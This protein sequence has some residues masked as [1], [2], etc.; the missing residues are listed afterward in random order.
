MTIETFIFVSLNIAIVSVVV[1]SIAAI[2]SLLVRRLASRHWILVLGLAASLCTFVAVPLGSVYQ[3]SLLPGVEYPV[4]AETTKGDAGAITVSSNTQQRSA[5]INDAQTDVPEI[6]V[7][8]SFQPRPARV[9]S[10]VVNKAMLPSELANIDSSFGNLKNESHTVKATDLLEHF[11]G[12]QH[13]GVPPVLMW[14]WTIAVLVWCAGTAIAFLLQ[15]KNWFRVRTA[16]RIKQQ[17]QDPEL[18]RLLSDVSSRLGLQQIPRAFVSPLIPCPVVSAGVHAQLILPDDYATRFSCE[19][20]QLILAHELAHLKRGDHRVVLLQTV[21][22]IVFWWNPILRFLSHGISCLRELICDGM[23]IELFGNQQLFARTMI[24]IAE[25][26]SNGKP[27]PTAQL[28]MATGDLEYRVRQILSDQAANAAMRSSRRFVIISAVVTLAVVASTAFAQISLET[29]DNHSIVGEFEVATNNSMFSPHIE[30]QPRSSDGR[31]SDSVGDSEIAI[32][33]EEVREANESDQGVESQSRS[34]EPADSSESMADV[35]FIGQRTGRMTREVHGQV[36]MPDGTPAR[37]S[38]LSLTNHWRNPAETLEADANGRFAFRCSVLGQ[39]FIYVATDSSGAFQKVFNLE[40]KS[41]C[42]L[43]DRIDVEIQLDHCIDREIRVVDPSGVPIAGANVFVNIGSPQLRHVMHG[44]SDSSG[45]FKYRHAESDAVFEIV[46]FKSGAGFDYLNPEA[47]NK[48]NEAEEMLRLTSA[49]DKQG[50]LV[51]SGVQ[52]RE[53]RVV[54]ES[55]RPVVG[56]RLSVKRLVKGTSEPLSVSSYSNFLAT[57]TDEQGRAVFDWFPNWQT[58]AVEASINA[59][60]FARQSKT[61]LSQDGGSFGKI[62]LKRLVRVS[63]TVVDAN[64]QPV[65]RVVVRARGTIPLED[66]YAEPTGNDGRFELGMLPNQRVIVS[67]DDFS[68]L[69]AIRR[70]DASVSELRVLY[71]PGAYSPIDEVL[72][73]MV[74][75]V[76]VDVQIVNALNGQPIKT[77]RLR[78]TRF[79]PLQAGQNDSGAGVSGFAESDGNGLA[80]LFLAPG[81][82]MLR[83]NDENEFVNL[84]LKAGQD[85]KIVLKTKSTN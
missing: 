56:A 9:D 33:R 48:N 84:N 2:A 60:D 14:G 27:Q 16:L 50:Q 52:R 77:D 3:L 21:V 57:E 34:I 68:H 6:V 64:G 44:K 20:L 12:S 4:A 82:Y 73:P 36:M 15:I 28:G 37:N 55:G 47:R 61:L 35:P 38:T 51:L 76:R 19:E 75:A 40:V 45:M 17:M 67:V 59:P 81:N 85:A 83:V 71:L 46:A 5:T 43:V 42:E 65:S 26:I 74:D 25:Q 7:D 10:D 58:K 80:T 22:L 70:E 29:N 30:N 69:Y 31:F 24:K 62:V 13:V 18:S 54:D 66:R 8:D 78:I 32:Q 53:V 72:L 79:A 1:S 63:G 41:K 23:A 11:G 49:S 39:P